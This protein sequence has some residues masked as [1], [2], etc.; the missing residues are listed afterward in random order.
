MP[1]AH[2]S[3]PAIHTVLLTTDTHAVC[4][5]ACV[6]V[7]FIY[8]IS[9]EAVQAD[10]MCPESSEFHDQKRLEK[11]GTQSPG[12]LTADEDGA[13]SDVREKQKPLQ[14]RKSL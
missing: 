2:V 3:L 11:G 10:N 1:T 4:V 7:F 9:Q 14:A 5:C 6:W 13:G 8:G 12:K